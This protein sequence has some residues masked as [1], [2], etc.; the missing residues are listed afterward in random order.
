MIGIMKEGNA[1]NT[2][3]QLRLVKKAIKGD[4]DAYGQLIAEHQEYLYKMAYLYVR[5]RK[6]VV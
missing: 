2:E 3:E 4:P 1:M 5:D 6:S